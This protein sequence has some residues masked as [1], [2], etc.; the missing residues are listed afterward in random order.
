MTAGMTTMMTVPTGMMT[1]GRRRRHWHG[2]G[3]GSRDP[4]RPLGSG[5]GIRHRL[6]DRGRAAMAPQLRGLCHRG[7][8][9]PAACLE[10]RRPAPRPVFRFRHRAGAGDRLS[11]RAGHG[12]AG[13]TMTV[14]LLA[15]LAL[16]ALSGMA[17]LAVEEGAGPLAG[18]VGAQSVP[19]WTMEDDDH[20][21]GGEI[22]EEIHEIAA[23][24]T[25]LLIML[26]VAGVIV[27]SLAHRENL[28]RA[29]ITGR[30]RAP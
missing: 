23:N 2:A 4:H 3:L 19:A 10:L 25:L 16:T 29:M 18:L 5:G 26:H 21:E 8:G 27:A 22:L 9:G 12:P 15:A 13:G 17:M 28:V 24:A 14:A 11:A 20:D 1:D 6:P 7:G 30:K